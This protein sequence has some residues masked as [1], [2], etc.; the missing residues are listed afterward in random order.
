M[1][2]K[3]TTVT[4]RERELTEDPDPIYLAIKDFL[5]EGGPLPDEMEEFDFRI[6]VQRMGRDGKAEHG[7]SMECDS[8]SRELMG[9]ILDDPALGPGR[10]IFWVRHRK[11]GS[12]DPWKL[13]KIAGVRITDPEDGEYDRPVSGDSAPPLS[14]GPVNVQPVV[15]GESLSD[16]MFLLLMK[17]MTDTN[18]A[19]LSSL[20]KMAGGGSGATTETILDA[21]RL[22][23]EMAGGGALSHGE[24]EGEPPD[25]EGL[26]E[27]LV[28]FGL[29]MAKKIT[30]AQPGESVPVDQM[31]QVAV[32]RGIDPETVL[33]NQGMEIR[34]GAPDQ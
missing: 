33:R 25:E 17:Q 29:D 18:N 15:Q 8:L 16:K 24:E 5:N 10:Y 30:E 26:M 12:G 19:I 6:T 34:E 3:E 9:V 11:G 2:T 13:T 14:S 21:I 27:K 4:R 28:K 22:G 7:H 1:A 20:A 32:D 23:G 31:R